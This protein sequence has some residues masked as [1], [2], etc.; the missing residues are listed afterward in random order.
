MLSSA[1]LPQKK[2]ERLF[3]LFF[4]W[5]CRASAPPNILFRVFITLFAQEEGGLISKNPKTKWQPLVALLK[6]GPYYGSDWYTTRPGEDAFQP[7]IDR[8]PEKA[9]KAR[10]LPPPSNLETYAAAITR[11]KIDNKVA[12]WSPIMIP[13]VDRDSWIKAMVVDHK[14]PKHTAILLMLYPPLKGHCCRCS[15]IHDITQ[16]MF[17]HVQCTI[18]RQGGPPEGF[19]ACE[20]MYCVQLQTHARRYWP[21]L[22][23]RCF[24]CLR[25]GHAQEDKVCDDVEVNLASPAGGSS[26]VLSR[27]DAGTGQPH[28][29]R[30]G[31][32][33][34][35]TYVLSR[36]W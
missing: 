35:L 29:E 21:P 13:G 23:L 31:V 12:P 4:R 20:Y 7:V 6:L 9:E 33:S 24:L 30:R 3:P 25:R 34:P 32:Q 36:R 27:P 16:R 26:R 22:N 11:V 17:C 18:L 28:Q 19:K 1:D 10:T 2:R 15:Q 8:T 14:T 5:V